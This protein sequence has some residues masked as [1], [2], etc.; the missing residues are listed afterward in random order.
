MVANHLGHFLAA[1]LL[2]QDLKERNSKRASQNGSGGPAPRLIIVGSITGNSNTVA[3]ALLSRAALV[4]PGIMRHICCKSR[5]EAGVGR[6]FLMV[7]ESSMR[8]ARLLPMAVALSF[9]F[10]AYNP[11][12]TNAA[13]WTAA[14][15]ICSD[16]TH[17][18]LGLASTCCCPG[19]T[20][21][22]V[23]CS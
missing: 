18:G 21:C 2:L 5:H 16:L 19:A 3:G 15:Q 12:L 4:M 14:L 11:A 7:M 6:A 20:T 23:P 17:R 8:A 10:A 22:H 13:L 9:P 1:N